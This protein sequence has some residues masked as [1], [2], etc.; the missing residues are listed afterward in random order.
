MPYPA[1]SSAPSQPPASA[2]AAP[3]PAPS[4]LS[5]QQSRT[6]VGQLRR[7]QVFR[8]YEQAFRETTGLPLA[9]RPIEAFDLPHHGDPKEN[10]FCALMA[11]S[12]HSCAA[13]LQL[14]KRVEEEAQL[15][16]KTLK[17]FA[18]MCDSAVPVRVG[19]NLIAFL[20]TGQILLHAPKQSDFSKATREL[21][22]LGTQ[23]DLK[24]LEEAYFQSRVITKKQYESIVRL[25]TIFAQHLSALSNQLM[26][27]GAAAESPAI[28]RARTFIAEHHADEL[29]LTEVA[30]SVNMSAF[31]FCKSFKKA[32]GMT[33]TDYLARVRIEKVKNLLLNPHKRVSEAAY[34]AG[35]QSLSQFNRVFR[36]IAGESPTTFRDRLHSSGSR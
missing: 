28:A 2:A 6:L 8:D 5:S 32:T 25:L 33:F 27:Q 19:E 4:R 30:R 20:Q 16:P 17:C 18:G 34:E 35:F 31:Y 9:L 22:K 21:V 3:A 29:S 23:I 12:N 15:E 7:S 36:R 14:Q 13:C 26:V 10:P 24:R 11:T 1:L